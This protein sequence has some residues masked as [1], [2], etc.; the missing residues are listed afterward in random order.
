MK[1]LANGSAEAPE[2]CD[3]AAARA[4]AEAAFAL[5]NAHAVE[6]AQI[7]RQ[8]EKEAILDKMIDRAKDPKSAAAFSSML[9]GVTDEQTE[10]ARQA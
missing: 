5:S 9:A 10:E 8:L 4:L 6:R 3:R 2:T 7:Q 1:N